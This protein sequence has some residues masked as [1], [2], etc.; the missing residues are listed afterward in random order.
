MKYKHIIWDWNG[1]L[2]DDVWLCVQSINILLKKYNKSEVSQQS[3]RELFDFP[4]KNYYQKREAPY[5]YKSIEYLEKKVILNA[6]SLS[7]PSQHL[8]ERAKNHF[9]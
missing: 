5:D 6:S 3:Y 8:A 2:L 1:T 4:V 9:S 7:S